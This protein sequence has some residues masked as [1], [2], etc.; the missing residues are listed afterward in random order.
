MELTEIKDKLNAYKIFY[1]KKLATQIR[2]MLET[3]K[4]NNYTDE[5]IAMLLQVPV[6][7]IKRMSDENWDGNSIG[8]N[9]ICMLFLLSGGEFKIGDTVMCELDKNS[10]RN[11]VQDAIEQANPSPKPSRSEMIDMILDKF[12]A[13]TDDE[14]YQLFQSI[15]KVVENKQQKPVSTEEEGHELDDNTRAYR[16]DITRDENGNGKVNGSVWNGQDKESFNLP[17]T[18]RNIKKFLEIIGW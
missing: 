11:L 18:D 10:I 5:E 3:A 14:L 6:D 7:K 2:G 17:L 9:T 8:I 13:H 15:S 4:E 16:I 1:R 12:G